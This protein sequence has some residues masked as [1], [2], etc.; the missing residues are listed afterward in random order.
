MKAVAFLLCTL[1]LFGCNKTAQDIKWQGRCFPN[2]F[3]SEASFITSNNGDSAFD[4]DIST[5]P[6]LFFPGSYVTKHIPA[7]K[8][9]EI[10]E[11]NSH[12]NNFLPV[13]FQPKM[14]LEKRSDGEN[15]ENLSDEPSLYVSKE[16]G[17]YDFLLYTKSENNYLYWGDCTHSSEIS[18]ECFRTME[19]ED[20]N[21]RYSVHKD[22]IATYKDI[23]NFIFEHLSMWECR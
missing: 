21:L 19:L 15:L 17:P 7:F 8:P 4:S 18:Y 5:A 1:V 13:N 11:N 2:E 16:R 20:M 3:L 14:E 12:L 22:N 9:I 23:E 6:I 10:T